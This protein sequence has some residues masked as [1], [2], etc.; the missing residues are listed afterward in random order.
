MISFALYKRELRRSLLT[1]LI[2]GAVMTLYISI[3]I[4]MYNPEMMKS[5][6]EMRKMLPELMS[7]VGMKA[8]ATS[9][10]GFM[11][12]Y[13]YGFILIVFPMV[14]SILRGNALIAKYV[15][16]HAMTA[17]LAAPI[18]RRT[19]VLTQMA[20][21]L[22][23]IAF[24]IVY[25]TALE[26]ICGLQFKGE[27]ELSKLLLLNAGLLCLQ[28]F[29]AGISFLASCVFNDSKYSIAIGGGLPALMYVLQMLANT[30]GNAEKAKYFTFFTWFDP[31]ALIAG[32]SSGLIGSSILLIGACL[33]FAAA[34]ITFCRKDLPI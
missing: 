17:L 29:I 19:I 13:L 16:S 27:L 21:L 34:G 33:L 7:A 14:F 15:D 20:V 8:G 12:S 1:L 30:G 23:G 26:I 18:K 9:L 3:I 32:D 31:N 10:L 5:L 2:F 25:A 11:S 24:L 22:T 28:L 6:E 4:S